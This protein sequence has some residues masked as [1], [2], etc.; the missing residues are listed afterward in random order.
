MRKPSESTAVPSNA[1]DDT[2]R[3]LTPLLKSFLGDR[4]AVVGALI[5][6]AFLLV[7]VLGPLLVTADPTSGDILN[8]LK[9]PSREH[10]F[11]TDG[12]GRDLFIRIVHGARLSALIGFL[13]VVAAGSIGVTLGALAGFFGGWLDMVIGRVVDTLLAFPG[14]LLAILVLAVLGPGITSVII[15][16]G[17]F[18]IPT[19]ARVMRGTVMSVSR[20]DYVEAATALGVRPM[21]VLA[22][23]VMKNSW[24]PILVL[25]SLNF[26]NAVLT[27]SALSFLGVG[28]QPPAPEWGAI[29]AEGR[30]YLRSAPHITTITGVV[31]FVTV[32][33]FNLVGDGLR[34]A[35]D[36]RT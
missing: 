7:A 25:S 3:R 12:L 14:I 20:Q 10:P 13:A 4:W 24:A 30:N 23:H 33:G 31:V 22:K 34:D 18:G 21:S 28:V 36:P 9:F 1:V 6:I 17:I 2:E 19:Y 15:A 35:M 27:A 11:G 32:L 5:V 29:I 8:R 16:V 26:G